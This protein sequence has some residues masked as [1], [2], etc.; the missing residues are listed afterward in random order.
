LNKNELLHQ[1]MIM[2]D[3]SFPIKMYRFTCEQL[4][5]VLF[6]PH[7]HEHIEL[8]YFVRGSATVECGS[9]TYEVKGGDVI[10]VNSNELHHGVC[11]S[12]D[13]IYYV[14]IFDPA[15]LHSSSV[16]AIET[17][18]MIPITQNRILFR[19]HIVG[20]PPLAACIEEI[21]GEIQSKDEGYELAIKSHL[22]KLMTV[23]IRRYIASSSDLESYRLQLQRMKQL[24]P[25]LRYIDEHYNEPLSVDQMAELA[26]ISRFHF[27]R[28][29]K[30]LTDKTLTEYVHFIRINR[31]ADLLRK[32]QMNVSEVALSVGYNDIYYFS[33]TFKKLKNA[34]PTEWRNFI[35]DPDSRI[36]DED[37]EAL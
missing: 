21:A 19:N 3:Y 36:G 30:K 20:D 10:V 14:L 35:P 9:A 26:G 18:Y 28:V 8:L 22:Y 15:L 24:E 27:S 17:K 13:L 1:H 29:F 5:F 34:S 23:L 4:Q 16:D 11:T 12:T 33:R 7:W 6:E 32:T 25:V 37:H 2:P 31:S